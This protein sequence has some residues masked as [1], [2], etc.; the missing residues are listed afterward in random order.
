MLNVIGAVVTCT[1]QQA[2]ESITFTWQS[3]FRLEVDLL[4]PLNF[5]EGSQISDEQHLSNSDSENSHSGP[6]HI[7]LG[8]E[9]I[10]SYPSD[11]TNSGPKEYQN[12]PEAG[13]FNSGPE[14][15]TYSDQHH[16]DPEAQNSDS[17]ES[18]QYDADDCSLVLE[19][20]VQLE[21]RALV[22]TLLDNIID[23]VV[24]QVSKVEIQRVHSRAV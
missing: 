12:Q 23:S 1:F 20:D 14:P 16:P 6:E 15:S 11:F 4:P 2:F 10:I 18:E 21:S 7:N 3:N 5:L 22:N 17:D 9:N 24:M 8:L 13:I 19:E